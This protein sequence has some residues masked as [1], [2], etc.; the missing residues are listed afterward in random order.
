MPAASLGSL[1]ARGAYVLLDLHLHERL[2]EDPNALPEEV[3][4]ALDLGLAQQLQKSYPHLVGHRAGVS[5][6]VR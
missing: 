2:G 1:M 5:Y 6:S 3:R 4:V